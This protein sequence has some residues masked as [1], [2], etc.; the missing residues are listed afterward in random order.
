ML[1]LL[2]HGISGHMGKEV[3]DI[4]KNDS[5]FDYI[6]G[7]DKN[8]DKLVI[9]NIDIYNSL[10]DVK[11]KIDV[12]I[13]FSNHLA[14]KDLLSFAVNNKIPIVIATTGQTEEEKN[15]IN[16]A[17]KKIPV[18]FS[19]NYSIGVNVLID[20]A[21]RTAKT[22]KDAEIEIVEVHHDRKIDAPSGTAL[23]IANAIKGVREN[24]TIVAG[25]NG[26]RKRTKDEIGISSIRMG[27]IAG[28][29]EV[30]ISTQNE[31][32]TLKH[33]AY[34]RAIFAE[35]AIYASKFLFDKEVGL[36]DMSSILKC[37]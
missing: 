36:Y 2:I 12:I 7:V 20:L 27:N 14:T 10:Q 33:E 9:D 26:E 19:A 28:I 6:C 1:K 24:A 13:D 32:V 37:E 3:L 35:G 34:N 29:H 11:L 18:F 15:M 22:M 4:A 23:A 30:M 17:S 5:D 21:K 8:T 25:R 16:D 31:T